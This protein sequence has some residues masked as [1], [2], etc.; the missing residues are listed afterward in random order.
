MFQTTHLLDSSAIQLIFQYTVK[1]G[2]E[3]H[4]KLRCLSFLKRLRLLLSHLSRTFVADD[5]CVNTSY[6]RSVA[7]VMRV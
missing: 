1:N 2:V 6:G 3:K 4:K 7:A 5:V